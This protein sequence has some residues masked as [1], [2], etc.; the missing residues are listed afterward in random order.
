MTQQRAH[1][2]FVVEVYQWS[3]CGDRFLAVRQEVAAGGELRDRLVG[4]RRGEVD[5]PQL[6]AWAGQLAR[7]VRDCH[8]KGIVHR[9]LKPEVRFITYM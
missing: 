5:E 7:G 3:L 2:A 9:D 4:D 8:A 6:F 1:S